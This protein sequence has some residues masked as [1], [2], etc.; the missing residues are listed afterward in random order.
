MKRRSVLGLAFA[1]IAEARGGDVGVPE[2]EG[3]QIVETFLVSL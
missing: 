2:R 3:R 1:P